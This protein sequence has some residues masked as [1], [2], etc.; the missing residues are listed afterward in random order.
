M[1]GEPAEDAKVPTA[2]VL[3]KDT[4]KDVK[5]DAGGVQKASPE[6]EKKLTGAEI[7]AKAKA[8]KAARRAQAKEV[9]VP[10]VPPETPAT[11]SS[12][13]GGDSKGGKS[14][15]KQDG[16]QANPAGSAKSPVPKPP[17][18]VPATVVKDAVPS[19]PMCFSHLAMAKK[20]AVARADKDVDQ[21]V[22]D[23]GQAMATFEVKDNIA[24]LCKTLGAFKEVH[25]LAFWTGS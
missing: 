3:K 6:G 18:L 24:R 4:K 8:E 14:K 16:P 22:L 21:I 20:H 13:V 12:Q 23:L 10:V 15:Q 17:V 25:F 2:Q 9:K 19:T 1:A 7:K 5:K 11:P